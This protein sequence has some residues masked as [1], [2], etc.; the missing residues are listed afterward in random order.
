MKKILAF[1][2]IL[3]LIYVAV[4]FIP[5]RVEKFALIPEKIDESWRFATYSFVHLNLK[6][7][8]EN[9]V[10]LTLIAFIALE[11][12]VAFGDFISTYFSSGFLSVIP[13]WLIFTFTALGASNAIFGGFGLISQETRKYN[14][15]GGVWIFFISALIFMNG[16][17]SLFYYGIKSGQFLFAIQQSLAHFSGLVFG[18]GIFFLLTKIRPALTKRKRYILR[19]D[20]G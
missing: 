7:L 8:V 20:H 5:D 16:I 3:V 6:H 14:I 10:G 18:I 15:K 11:L 19:G 12:K 1:V 2:V 9:I 4:F 13:M 17:I